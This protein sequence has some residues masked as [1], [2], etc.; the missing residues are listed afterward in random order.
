MKKFFSVNVNKYSANYN[1]EVY[2]PSSLA[3]PKDNAVSFITKAHINQCEVFSHCKNNLVFWPEDY[4]VPQELIDKDNVFVKCDNPHLRFCQ[5]FEE[6]GIDNLSANHEVENI[7]GALISPKAV[8]GSNTSIFPLAYIGEDVS[9]GSNCY[10]ASGGKI[11]GSVCIGDNT[12]IKENTV[13]GA[14]SITTDRDNYGHGVKMPQFGGVKIGN[15]VTIGANSVIARGAIDDTI[16]ED[17]VFID[18]C[19]LISH[20]SSIGARTFVVG[21]TMTFGSVHVGRDSLISGNSVIRNGVKV[22][23][24]VVVGMGAVVI[25]DVP[26]GSVVKGNPAK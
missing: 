20:N 25:K 26:N 6:N 1:F 24:N 11:V 18:N 23:E 22:G 19:C 14:D 5:F 7:N 15:H 16:I 4:A 3:N 9:I 17:E 2:R 13:I 10:I 12:V 21:E 8:I